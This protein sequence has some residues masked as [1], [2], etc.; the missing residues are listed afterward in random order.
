[1]NKMVDKKSKVGAIIVAAGSNQRMSGINKNFAPLV[2]KPLLA[3]SVDTCQKCSLVQQIVI[4]L[5]K[6]DMDEGQGLREE[7]DWAKVTLCLGGARRQDSVKEGLHQLRDCAWVM[8]HDG[9]RPFLTEDLIEDGLKAAEKTGAAIAAVP[10]KDTIKLANDKRLVEETL[11]RDRLW[12]VQTP[13]IFCYD[14]INE[15]YEKL[16][17]EV[18]DDAAAVE[19]LGHKVKL[20]MGAYDNI[21][22][23]TLEDM[24]SAKI[25]A[26]YPL[27]LRGANRRSN[28]LRVGIGYDSHPLVLGR[29][30]I[31]GG[32]AIPHDKGLSG[33]SDAD[34]AIHAMIDA[35]CG[36]AGLGDIGTLFPSGKPEYKDI[37][38]LVLLSR[39]NEQV[40]AKGFKVA[41]IDVTIIAQ[42]PKL[43]PFIPEMKKRI[44]Q[45]LGL[46]LT[47]VSIK[48]TTNNGLGFIGREEGIAAQAVALIQG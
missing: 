29:R 41:N 47:Q 7:R 44:S 8:I 6:K 38:S 46:D 39:T 19:R 43:S 3:W 22:V 35:L 5:S 9:A 48:A 28:L 16:M 13:Q 20:Y 21:K 45:V 40:R 42:S 33:W 23:T 24:A 14:I 17:V 34:V 37:S 32:V 4:V 30:L 27:S 18:T 1:M 25:I 12:A 26:G 36:A 31:L 2:G 10:V 11:Q 15:A